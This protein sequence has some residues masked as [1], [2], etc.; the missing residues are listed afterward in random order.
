MTETPK[1]RRG[2]HMKSFEVV[3]NVLTILIIPIPRNYCRDYDNS[4]FGYSL[5]LGLTYSAKS[6]GLN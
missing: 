2:A 6:I 1:Q 5:R 3:Q 4:V